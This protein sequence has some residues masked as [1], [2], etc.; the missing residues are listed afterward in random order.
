MSCTC[1][2]C[3]QEEALPRHP[4]LQSFLL[5]ALGSSPAPLRGSQAGH[6]HRRGLIVLAGDLSAGATPSKRGPAVSLLDPCGNAGPAGDPT[7]VLTHTNGCARGRLTGPLGKLDGYWS[8]IASP[9]CVRFENAVKPWRQGGKGS[10]ALQTG[11]AR[12]GRVGD[13]RTGPVPRVGTRR[14]HAADR[15]QSRVSFPAW[16]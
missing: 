5:P 2:A 10:A 12:G 16:S 4:D 14:V 1:F 8:Q 15:C 3:K 13:G 11:A 7:R 9:D 6:E